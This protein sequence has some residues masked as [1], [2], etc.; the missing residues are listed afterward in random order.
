MRKRQARK[1]FYFDN[2]YNWLK[3]YCDAP[4]FG[5]KYI[6]QFI[7]VCLTI[8]NVFHLLKNASNNLT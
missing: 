3:K 4:S 6:C 7:E 1:K 5:V 2:K 8:L